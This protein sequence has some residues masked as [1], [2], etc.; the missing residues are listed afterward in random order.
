MLDGHQTNSV[1]PK[2]QNKHLK[3]L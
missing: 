2:Q 3:R 1:N